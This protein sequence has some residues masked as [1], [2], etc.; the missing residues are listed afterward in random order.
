MMVN[1]TPP[2]KKPPT[3]NLPKSGNGKTVRIVK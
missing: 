2:R 3:Q 1:L